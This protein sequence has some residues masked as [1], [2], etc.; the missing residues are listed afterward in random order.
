M[1]D[2]AVVIPFCADDSHPWFSPGRLAK[3]NTLIS[4]L[5]SL[6]YTP[7]IFN[8]SPSLDLCTHRQYNIS[9]Y[10]NPLLR[11]FS[12]LTSPLPKD[13]SNISHIW[14][15]NSRFPEMLLSYRLKLRCSKARIVCQIEDLPRARKK[16]AGIIGYLESIAT[17]FFLSHCSIVTCVSQDVLTNV[18]TSY[19]VNPSR[20]LLFP[21]L[22]SESYIACVSNRRAP[23]FSRSSIRILYAGD[24]SP[25]KG[26]D[27][28]F[29]AFL[30]L[31]RNFKLHLAGPLNR[32]LS[33]RYAAH[34][35]VYIHG[36]IPTSS[37]NRLYS[38]VDI[39]VN[40]H[41]QISQLSSIFPFKNVEICA[42]GAFPLLSNYSCAS[43][44]NLAP[45]YF[46]KSPQ[47][48]FE[49]LTNAQSTWLNHRH[50]IESLAARIRVTYSFRRYIPLFHSALVSS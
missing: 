34:P 22:L 12:L 35:R 3:T 50:S 24:Y 28:L 48:L 31:P 40:P 25:E 37:L 41:R 33:H 19:H 23:L 21:P 39:V 47:D 2:V 49:K 38:L 6:S 11:L 18:V 27:D 1:T 26:V 45:I 13:I 36:N 5:S 9:P 14:V 17:R 4:I 32:S 43:E 7:F 15:Y 16:N 46:F 8:T 29:D 10:K 30:R 44:L 20:C 42:S